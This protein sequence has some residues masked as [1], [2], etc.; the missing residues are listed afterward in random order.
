MRD[1]IVDRDC[2]FNGGSAS[3][4]T[5]ISVINQGGQ[6]ALTLGNGIP[7]VQAINGGT[8]GRHA[9]PDTGDDAGTDAVPFGQHLTTLPV[10]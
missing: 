4:S 1:W 6:G 5:A 7:L 9:G 3:G 8:I 10:E 2:V